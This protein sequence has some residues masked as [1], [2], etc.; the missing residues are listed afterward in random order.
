[1]TTEYQKKFIIITTINKPTQATIKYASFKDWQLIVVGDLKTPHVLYEDMKDVIYL[2]PDYQSATYPELSEAIGWNKIQRRTIGFIEAYKRCADIIASVDDD[3]IP[4]DD[5]GMHIVIGVP[6][7]CYYYE[8]NETCFDPLSATNYSHLWHRGFP[9]QL[10]K[11][12][13]KFKITRRTIVPDIQANFWNGD[14]D[15]D[16]I[17]RMEHSP[18]CFFD[19]NRFPF[20]TNVFSPFN[21]QNT[22]ITRKVLE[23]YLALPFI[24]RMDDIW[25]AYY[26][27]A[28]GFK[29]IYCKS[30]VFQDR[31]EQNLTKNMKDEFI[32]YEKTIELLN[33]KTVV[34]EW[35]DFLPEEARN[36]FEE[37]RKEI[38]KYSGIGETFTA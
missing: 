29:V 9:L 24:G 21:Q 5:W 2:H 36:C 22:I 19:E 14:P 12:K 31:N 16:A 26:V 38:E 23:H 28:L 11:D 15:I 7:D 13:N 17:C 30:T 37:Y 1:M 35:L 32:G 8:T 25:P 33:A 18:M 10:L 3:N 20:A 4:L 27:E 6:T 34:S